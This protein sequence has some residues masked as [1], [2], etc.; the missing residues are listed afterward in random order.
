MNSQ[1]LGDLLREVVV[2]RQTGSPERNSDDAI[3][4]FIKIKIK[5]TVICMGPCYHH[6]PT[7]S[8]NQK[9]FGEVSV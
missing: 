1:A 9:H 3:T 2:V 7:Q 5:L 8:L 4:L 6:L